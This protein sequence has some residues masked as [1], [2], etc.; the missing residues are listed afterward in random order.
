VRALRVLGLDGD[1]DLLA[2]DDVLGR[3]LQDEQLPPR[4]RRTGGADGDARST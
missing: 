4:R 1:L 3:K 2:R